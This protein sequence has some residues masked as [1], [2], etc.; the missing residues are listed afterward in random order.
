MKRFMILMLIV[1]NVQAAAAEID[2]KPWT[3]HT[4]D[5]SSD[6]ADGVKI[7]DINADGL[8]DVTTGWEEGGV[9]RVYL[10]PG[11]AKVKEKWPA[12]TIGNTPSV[13]DAVFV[14]LDGDGAID[15]VSSCEGDEKSMRVH[16][17][18]KMKEGLLE[19]E[20]W[21][22][23]VIAASKVADQQWMY[24]MPAQI[25]GQRGV[26]LVAGSKNKGAQ[27]GWLE[28][29][30]NP[31]DL[32]AWKWHPIAPAGWIMSIWPVDMDADGDADVV[33]SDRRGKMRG[34]HW[35]ENP[36]QGEEQKQ[37]WKP[38]S[39]GAHDK[40]VMSMC[41]A[42]LDHDGLQDALVAVKDM[43][44][45]WLR[46]LDAAGKSWETHVI[47]ADHGAGNTRAVRVANLTR[48]HHA[49]LLVT[50]WIADG[51]HGVF[52]LEG[53]GTPLDG[54]WKFHQISG[55]EKGSKFDRIELLDIDGDGGLDLLTCEENEGPS[56]RGMG[57]IWYRNPL[58]KVQ[59]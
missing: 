25:D 10:N 15:V 58:G 40:E 21:K 14:D 13:E 41:L 51:K 9:T 52:W 5:D 29:P 45:L 30:E 26:D 54:G 43:N 12:V 39:M 34:C 50:T 32:S 18:P 3:C 24:A 59:Y 31:R 8:L 19:P 46:R 36:G 17:A 6:G 2:G 44:I 16:W 28:S 56:S 37:M 11:A 49:D 4:I 1:F 55:T 22:Q 53:D 27:V 20:R 48:D 38:H 33:V 47:N 57:V 7:A 42:D 23:E 35:F